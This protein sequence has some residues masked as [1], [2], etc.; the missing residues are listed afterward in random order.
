[1]N[2]M[3]QHLAA[4]VKHLIQES[5]STLEAAAKLMSGTISLGYIETNALLAILKNDSKN[6]KD[7]L[8]GLTLTELERLRDAAADLA[9]ACGKRLKKND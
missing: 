3:T 1:M 4:K 7:N 5:E 8:D 6:L 9:I 2:L